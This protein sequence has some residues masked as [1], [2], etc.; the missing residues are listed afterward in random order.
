MLCSV[1]WA[2]LRAVLIQSHLGFG[3]LTAVKDQSLQQ[4]EI[5]RIFAMWRR[6]CVYL[7]PPGVTG[8]QVQNGR[9]D[10]WQYSTV[11]SQITEWW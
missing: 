5:R 9:W 6:F 2:L 1:A 7:W 4:D 3:H 8:E 10:Q 11:L